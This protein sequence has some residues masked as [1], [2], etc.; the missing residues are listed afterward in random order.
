MPSGPLGKV[1]TAIYKLVLEIVRNYT[2]LPPV[3]S[4]DGLQWDVMVHYV[5]EL[6]HEH[7]S[8]LTQYSTLCCVDR[9]R[10]CHTSANNT[11]FHFSSSY[12]KLGLKIAWMN[13]GG[14]A[15]YAEDVVDYGFLPN[16]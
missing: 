14:W 6:S 9:S 10:P 2:S 4:G 12:N 8:C 5:K 13:L 3:H 16:C 11:S 15:E 7:A 1:S